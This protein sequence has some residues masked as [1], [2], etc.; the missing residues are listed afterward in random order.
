MPTVQAFGKYVDQYYSFEDNNFHLLKSNQEF[1]ETFEIGE[2][3]KYKM[4]ISPSQDRNF[5]DVGE[6]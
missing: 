4:L 2:D 6:I 1:R 5:N 3:E